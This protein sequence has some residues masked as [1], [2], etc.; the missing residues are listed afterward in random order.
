M[1]LDQKFIDNAISIFDSL[2]GIENEYLLVSRSGRFSLI[3]A[4]ERVSVFKSQFACLRYILGRHPDIILF[5]SLFFGA[6]L[7]P[8]VSRNTALVWISWGQDL[9][10]DEAE[11][12]A[13]S[14]PFRHSLFM[15][16]TRKWK[17]SRKASIKGRLRKS[18]KAFVRNL[19]RSRA[20]RRIQYMSTC[21]PYEYPVVRDIYPHLKPFYFDYIDKPGTVL[22]RCNGFNILVGNSASLNCNH[23]DIITAL[24][25]CRVKGEKIVVPLSYAGGDEYRAAVISEGKRVFGEKFKPLTQFMTIDEYAEILRSCGFAVMGFLRQ[26]ATKNIQ[27]LLHQG[28]KVFFYRN[29]DIFR[30]FKNSGYVVFSIEDNLNDAVLSSLLSDTEVQ[31]NRTLLDEH[32]NYGDNLRKV[33]DS[34]WT[35]LEGSG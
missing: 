26:Q 4:R 15:P 3:N 18:A 8:F 17:Q 24:S 28:T 35:I 23:L 9:Y 31:R 22:P 30:F 12:F 14:Y 29:T 27:L 16:E 2:P 32:F 20:I 10:K 13:S 19:L 21:L 7:V 6:S 33:E 1:I 34:V 5:H 11:V 25:E